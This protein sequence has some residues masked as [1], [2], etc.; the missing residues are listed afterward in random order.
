MSIYLMLKLNFLHLSLIISEQIVK[1]DF[2]LE[3]WKNFN[4]KNF[5]ND[6]LI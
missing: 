4:D 3:S 6:L 2:L 1:K 5:F